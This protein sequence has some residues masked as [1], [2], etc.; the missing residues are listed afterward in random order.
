M[1]HHCGHLRTLYGLERRAILANDYRSRVHRRFPCEG[2]PRARRSASG[3]I[4]A[5]RGRW[6]EHPSCG[7]ADTAGD[8]PFGPT[9]VRRRRCPISKSRRGSSRKHGSPDAG[10]CRSQ[11]DPRRGKCRPSPCCL[12]D[13]GPRTDE[14]TGR[15]WPE[16]TPSS[17]GGPKAGLFFEFARPAPAKEVDVG[18]GFARPEQ[19]HRSTTHDVIRDVDPR[20]VLAQ[21]TSGTFISSP[22]GRGATDRGR[23]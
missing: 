3:G 10:P 13:R 14:R 19:I 15:G 11:A 2:A 20:C 16:M 5:V 4:W 9:H 1:N 22:L 6:S 7:G 8:R 18:E 21:R 23:L 17:S 12:V